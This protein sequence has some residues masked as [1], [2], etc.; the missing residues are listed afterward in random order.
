MSTILRRVFFTLII[1]PLVRLLLGVNAR[2]VERLPKQGPAVLV[3]N[4]NSHLD[5]LVLM[6]ISPREALHL[7]RPVAAADYFLKCKVLAWFAT[8]IMHI[9]PVDRTARREGTDP[10][11]AA[12]EALERSEIVLIFP[13]GSRGEPEQLAD[14]KKG[15]AHLLKQFPDVPVVPIFMHGLGRALPRGEAVLV[16][17]ICDVFVGEA[18]Y[19]QSSVEAFMNELHERLL[20]LSSGTHFPHWDQK[21]LE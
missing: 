10:L 17:V 12:A 1:F 18:F 19:Y 14:F 2:H 9:L 3:A 20:S 5:T 4:H 13:E 21:P 8:T 15:I 7:I 6:S 11:A 16:P